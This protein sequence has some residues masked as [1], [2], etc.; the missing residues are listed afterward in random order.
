MLLKY[1]LALVLATLPALANKTRALARS[2]TSA[3]AVL[4]LV[5]FLCAA[6]TGTALPLAPATAVH[7]PEQQA[8]LGVG[9]FGEFGE[10]AP[11][12]WHMHEPPVFG[13]HAAH[14][15]HDVDGNAELALDHDDLDLDLDSVGLGQESYM[16]DQYRYID[17]EHPHTTDSHRLP[18]VKHDDNEAANDI[19][20]GGAAAGFAEEVAVPHP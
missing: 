10:P 9:E 11:P 5:I 12:A 18:A 19:G 6:P 8:R 16:Y 17:S 4:C 2:P 13:D 7:S 14:D 3:A 15:K 20:G 1:C